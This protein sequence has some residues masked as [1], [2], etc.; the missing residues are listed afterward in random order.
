MLA[1]VTKRFLSELLLFH[2]IYDFLRWRLCNAFNEKQ[3]C[4]GYW[5]YLNL[6]IS[7]S[8][9]KSIVAYMP[10]GL[11]W[12]LSFTIQFTHVLISYAYR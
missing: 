12:H 6:T 1:F 8:A 3:K 5:E 4:L 11:D 2:I 7:F 10:S 9:E